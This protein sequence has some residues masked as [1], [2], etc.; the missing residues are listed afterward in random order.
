M[1][2]EPFIDDPEH[3]KEL[4][5]QRFVVLR[6]AAVVS[7]CHRWVQDLLRHHLS[8]LSVSYPARAHVTLAGF[9]AGTSLEAVQDLVSAWAL[10]VPPLRIEVEGATLFPPPFQIAVLKVVK[11]AALLAA[12]QG[13]RQKAA[14]PGLTMSTVIPAEEWVFH[15]SL[16][17]CAKLNAT[18]WSEVGRFMKALQVPN[19]SCVQQ[20]VEVVGFDGGAEYSGGVRSLSGRWYPPHSRRP[21]S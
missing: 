17:Y 10:D 5:R 14:Q 6:P 15:M 8:G 4:D 9:A 18:E 3:I 1:P 11:T 16:A 2:Y 7:D 12:L 21:W 13:L 20:T 19:A